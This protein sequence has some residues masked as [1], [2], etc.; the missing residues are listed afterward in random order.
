ME[1]TELQL[2][3]ERTSGALAKARQQLELLRDE[4]ARL[5][6]PP[7]SLGFFIAGYAMEREAEVALS[8]RR[9]RVQVAPGVDLASLSTGQRV[10]LN[11]QMVMVG[12]APAAREGTLCVITELRGLDRVI[13]TTPN[14]SEV[15]VTLAG[16]LRS[17]ALRVG[18]ELMVDLPAALALERVPRERVEQLLSPEVPEVAWSEVGG[19]G[20]QVQAIRDAVELPFRQPEL[21]KKFGLRPPRGVL[22]YGPPGCG[23]TLIAKA[24]ATALANPEEGEPAYFLSLKGPQLL[25]KYVGETERQLRALFARARQLA[26]ASRPVVIFF[27]EMEA[28][29][30]VRGSGISSDLETSVVPQFLAELDGLETLENVIVIGASNREDMI[31]PAV[32]RGGRLDVRIEVSRPDQAGAQE[33]LGIHLGAQIPFAEGIDRAALIADLAAA[34]YA[35]DPANRVLEIETAEGER[36]YLMAKDLLSGAALAAIAN[37]AKQL[38]VKAALDGQALGISRSELWQ[39]AESEV[40]ELAQLAAASKPSVYAPTAGLRG[41]KIT[42]WEACFAGALP[43]ANK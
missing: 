5:R 24:I 43:E 4:V 18:E 41:R 12:T 23:K 15:L 22:L 1:N 7:S 38:A 29:F 31:D 17:G 21:F 25:N 39:A 32:L 40:Q 35:D 27:D 36:G 2:Q 19:L 20:P 13:V 3:L 26:T 28:L 9:L 11:D 34:L 8:G 14:G 30:R 33:I 10:R 6:V 42:T 16:P 37:R